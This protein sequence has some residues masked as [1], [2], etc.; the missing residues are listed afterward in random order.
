MCSIKATTAVE[1]VA[2][3][4]TNAKFI[5]GADSATDEVVLLHILQV[6]PPSPI[7]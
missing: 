1:N 4:V 6:P 5:G 2:S 7:T 3:A